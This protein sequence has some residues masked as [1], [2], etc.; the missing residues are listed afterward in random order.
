MEY[1]VA[2]MNLMTALNSVPVARA[3]LAGEP[4]R[5]DLLGREQAELLAL[6]LLAGVERLGLE[7]W[8]LHV[9]AERLRDEV[10]DHALVSPAELAGLHHSVELAVGP[11][12]LIRRER[13]NE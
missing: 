13:E 12:H 11:V 8:V 6:G 9:D 5:A 7:R 3:A 4:I 1:N 10:R 2:N